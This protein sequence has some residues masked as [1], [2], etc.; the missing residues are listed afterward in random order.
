MSVWPPTVIVVPDAS[1]RRYG[2]PGRSP[3]AAVPVLT[4][5]VTVDPKVMPVRPVVTVAWR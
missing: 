1:T 5:S 2:P 4:P 3:T